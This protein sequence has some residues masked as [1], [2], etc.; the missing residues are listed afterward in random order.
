M[1]YGVGD[2][3]SVIL[4]SLRRNAHYR[5]RVED[6]GSTLIYEGHDQRRGPHVPSPKAVDQTRRS[7]NRNPVAKRQIPLSRAGI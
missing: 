6:D 2:N 7:S 4:M 5:D 3:H 1:N